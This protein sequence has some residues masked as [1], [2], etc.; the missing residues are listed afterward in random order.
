MRTPT[1]ASCY[2]KT[3]AKTIIRKGPLF[4]IPFLSWEEIWCLALSRS[5]FP[6]AVFEETALGGKQIYN[7]RY[8]II[9]RFLS[10]Y[11]GIENELYRANAMRLIVEGEIKAGNSK[12]V[13]FCKPHLVDYDDQYFAKQVSPNN[14][15]GR[16]PS[17]Y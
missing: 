2:E 7:T 5:E 17:S 13:S 12:I 8:Y 3:T 15:S 14:S 11:T 1:I 10:L 4:F 9:G 6:R 16:H